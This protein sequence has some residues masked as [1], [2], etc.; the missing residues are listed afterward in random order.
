MVV[1]VLDER[2]IGRE[3]GARDTND[4]MIWSARVAQSRAR[5][6][7][8]T[9]R[10]LRDRPA[11]A[12]AAME[13]RFSSDQLDAVMLVATPETDAQWAED[14]PGWT[15]HALRAKARQQR[16]VPVE[17][18]VER[19][20][21]RHLTMRW[22]ERR[23][24]F[25]FSGELPDEAGAR[26]QV[27]LTRGA[28]AIGPDETGQWAPFEQR[29]ADVLVE[30]L[31]GAAADDTEA[32]RATVVLH[33][34]EAAL[35]EESDVPGAYLD[36]GDD[37]IPV[38]NETVRRLACDGF[39]QRA[40]DDANGVPIRLGRRTRTVPPHL[41]RLLK[42]RDRHCRAPGCTSTRGLQAHHRKHWS[43]GGTTDLDNLILLCGR[44]H[45]LLHENRW[46]IRGRL[47]SPETVEFRRRNG[48]MITPYRPPPL[49]AQVRERL[50]VSTR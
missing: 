17:A 12:T 11:I 48:D 34:P 13:G 41:F 42:H 36:A 31:G 14:G 4:W 16:T 47:S 40:A 22:N 45:R 28:E 26:V 5:A 30:R 21:R 29:C 7:V 2:E 3:D 15:P 18:A 32:Q 1:A 49:D 44:H 46:E 35:L 19:D 23:G 6:L 37:G 25:R 38:A 24:T 27:A 20:A 10:A 50:L 39:V 33:A 8:E 43:D 9:A